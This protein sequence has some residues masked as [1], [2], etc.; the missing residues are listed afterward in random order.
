MDRGTWRAT[1][2][3]VAESDMIERLSTAQHH[4]E[5]QGQRSWP[6]RCDGVCWAWGGNCGLP[7][8]HPPFSL[9]LLQLVETE[10][11]NLASR[12]VLH[13]ISAFSVAP[14]FCLLEIC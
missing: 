4:A 6:G 8:P 5:R 2:H 9:C 10:F 14:A 3:G 12:T 7:I 11:L 1:V 13:N